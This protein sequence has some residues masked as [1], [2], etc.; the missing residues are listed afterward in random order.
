MSATLLYSPVTGV[1][2][3]PADRA[4]VCKKWPGGAKYGEHRPLYR[5]AYR[6]N[7]WRCEPMITA[8]EAEKLE[9]AKLRALVLRDLA[10][11]E[12][13]IKK[14]PR[15]RKEKGAP[16]ATKAPRKVDCKNPPKTRKTCHKY[17]AECDFVWG[18][19]DG[20]TTECHA[21]KGG[22]R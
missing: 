11:K 8:K 13:H 9:N 16:K 15:A 5:M 21:C 3:P 22:R 2:P 7:Q 6:G 10:K 14:P 19:T 18:T 12:R 17:A 1:R 20:N 4:E